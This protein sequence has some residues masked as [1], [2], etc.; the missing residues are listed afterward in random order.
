ARQ[1][2]GGT[3]VIQRWLSCSKG[4][5][6]EAEELDFSDHNSGIGMLSSLTRQIPRTHNC[7]MD[8]PTQQT[9]LKPNN[10]LWKKLS[11]KKLSILSHNHTKEQLLILLLNLHLNLN[12]SALA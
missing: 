7:M 2:K 4:N 9:I 5:S 8:L 12:L 3:R 1:T 6:I 10:Q 11:T